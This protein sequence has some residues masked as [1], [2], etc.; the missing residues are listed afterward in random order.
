LN[1]ND[2]NNKTVDT[3]NTSHDDGNNVLHDIL[4][5]GKEKKA[6]K[7][8]RVSKRGDERKKEQKM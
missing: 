3:Q 6:K 2:G 5:K 1:E 4:R 8:D 7:Q